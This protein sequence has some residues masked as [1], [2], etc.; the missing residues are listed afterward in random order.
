MYRG[1]HSI[2]LQIPRSPVTCVLV[3]SI[4]CILCFWN[5]LCR[6]LAHESCGWRARAGQFHGRR[7]SWC[8]MW[9]PR[10]MYGWRPKLSTFLVAWVT[11]T[12][13]D[14]LAHCLVLLEER[15]VSKP[16]ILTYLVSMLDIWWMGIYTQ[17]ALFTT[18]LRIRDAHGGKC[19]LR[20]AGILKENRY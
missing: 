18:A 6:R 3:K 4:I 5:S 10:I 8:Q 2:P 11:C 14:V 20:M 7:S 9:A 13:I 19:T 16:S 15:L 17:Y 1:P 12:Y